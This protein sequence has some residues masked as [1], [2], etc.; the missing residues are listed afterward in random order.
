MAVL[1]QCRHKVADLLGGVALAEDGA[2][3]DAGDGCGFFNR[4]AA[5][6]AGAFTQPAY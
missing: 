5:L 1:F 4:R 3:A 2:L 6:A